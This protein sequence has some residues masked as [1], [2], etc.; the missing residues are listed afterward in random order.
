MTQPRTDRRLDVAALTPPVPWEIERYLSAESAENTADGVVPVGR[1]G[2]VGV[3]E[4]TLGVDEHDVTGVASRFVKAP[5]QLTRPLYVDRS[6]R[7]EAFVYVRTTGGGLAQNDRIRQI[8]RLEPGARATV[9]TQAGTPV[10]RMNAGFASQWVSLHV[11]DGA[12][13][14][15]LPGQSILFAGSRLLQTTDAVVDPGG[16]LLA[17]EVMLTGRLARG[18]RDGFDLLSQGFRVE[19]SGRPLLSD[20]LC[21]VG[22]GQGNNEMQLSGWPVWGTVLIVPP[23]PDVVPTLLAEIRTVLESTE[24][25]SGDSAAASTMVGDEGVTVR[26]TGDDPVSVRALV[27]MVHGTARQ[28]ILG[29]PAMDLRRM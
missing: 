9:T 28:V 6:D 19:R 8:I 25:R 5:M 10:H 26:V 15:Y 4:V 16:T 29:R 12:V 23:S 21:V 13:C 2:K 3:L 27:G 18:E 17:A 20:T 24:S 11:P 22:A 14:E 7:G 1:P